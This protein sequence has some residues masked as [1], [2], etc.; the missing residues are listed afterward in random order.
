MSKPYG[1]I[2]N[3]SYLKGN[4]FLISNSLVQVY[5]SA[6]PESNCFFGTCISLL[7][8]QNTNAGP[9]FEPLKFSPSPIS[10][11]TILIF[12][13][14]FILGLPNGLFPWSFLIQILYGFL[15]CCISQQVFLG[16]ITLTMF[17]QECKLLWTL[18][19]FPCPPI[20]SSF[21]GLNGTF[22]RVPSVFFP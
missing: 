2:K 9:C 6:S 5:Y 17:G 20:A 3:N 22:P 21:L 18:W 15:A 1:F 13:L 8:S 14:P 7:F 16:L 10:L 12:F 4:V 19:S 11:R